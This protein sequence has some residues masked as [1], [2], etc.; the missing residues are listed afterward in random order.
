MSKMFEVMFSFLIVVESHQ[1]RAPTASRYWLLFASFFSFK[2]SFLQGQQKSHICSQLFHLIPPSPRSPPPPCSSLPLLIISL[3][4]QPPPLLPL[5]SPRGGR[6]FSWSSSNAFF[7][8]IHPCNPFTTN[9]LQQN[10]INI[11][12][13]IRTTFFYARLGWSYHFSER[14]ELMQ[15]FAV[16]LL[17]VLP[18]VLFMRC[19]CCCCCL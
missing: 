19:C 3:Y 7:A 17:I 9:L 18:G 12:S 10:N 2:S 14:S 5:I 4:P 1:I 16:C 6:I 15:L 8:S 13:A 11:L